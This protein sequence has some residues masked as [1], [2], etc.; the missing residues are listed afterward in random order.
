MIKYALK[1]DQGHGFEAWFRNSDAYDVEADEGRVVCPV[2]GSTV[3]SKDIM[4]PAVARSGAL[5]KHDRAASIQKE[6]AKVARKARERIEKTH[7]YVGDKFPEEAR[8]IY[9]GETDERLIYGEA[10]GEDVKALV[11][12]GVPV[13][14]MPDVGPPAEGAKPPKKVN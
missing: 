8:R 3:V 2:C 14:P 4:A 10:K 11:E 12:E 9:Y 7:D 5:S 6:I 13:A 1:C